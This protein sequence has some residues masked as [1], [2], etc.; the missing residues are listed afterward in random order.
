MQSLEQDGDRD[1]VL[2]SLGVRQEILQLEEDQ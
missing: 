2:R 1:T